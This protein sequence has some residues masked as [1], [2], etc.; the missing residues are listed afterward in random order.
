[1]V[2]GG[3][4]IPR[5]NFRINEKGRVSVDVHPVFCLSQSKNNYIY[6]KIQIN[7]LHHDKNMI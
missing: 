7:S 2:L 4:Y 3:F 6:Y 1:M 5:E